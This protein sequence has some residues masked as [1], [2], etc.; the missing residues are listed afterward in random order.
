MSFFQKIKPTWKAV[1]SRTYGFWE[2]FAIV[3]LLAIASTVGVFA[4]IDGRIFDFFVRNTPYPSAIQRQVVLVDTPVQSFVSPAITWETISAEL[5]AL[6]AK[7]V[8][9]S[10][11]PEG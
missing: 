5:L 6:G 8:V 10:V 3:L 4:P 1:S 2:S 11:T 7:K 9:F